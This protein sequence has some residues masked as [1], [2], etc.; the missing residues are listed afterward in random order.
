MPSLK[1]DMVVRNL[2]KK[3]FEQ[4]ERAH[5]YLCYVRS[6]GLRTSIRTKVSHGSKSDIT[7]GLVSAMARQCHITTQ[8][9]KQ[10]AECTL[11]RQQY[12]QLLTI[13]GQFSALRGFVWVD[14]SANRVATAYTSAPLCNRRLT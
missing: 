10:L 11:D 13:G 3:G 4:D 12:E 9:F 14:A 6:D 5:P 1:K 2:I 7:T 8:Q